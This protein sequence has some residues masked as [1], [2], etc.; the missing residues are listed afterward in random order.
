MILADEGRIDLSE[1]P[2]E[3]RD[4]AGP[5]LGLEAA[6]EPF[7]RTHVCLGL[8]LCG[9]SRE[10]AAAELWIS[11]ATLYRRIEKLGLKGFELARA[12]RE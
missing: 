10:R 3:V 8:K 5:G 9:G 6:V 12:A 1:I 2:G 11:E 4:S 7:E